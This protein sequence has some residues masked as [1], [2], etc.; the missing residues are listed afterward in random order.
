[1]A[2]VVMAYVVAWLMFIHIPMGESNARSWLAVK[3]RT[4]RMCMRA[5]PHVPGYMSTHVPVRMPIRMSTQISIRESV[6][7]LVIAY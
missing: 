7:I 4:A 5:S 1:M 6:R 3:S 2:Y